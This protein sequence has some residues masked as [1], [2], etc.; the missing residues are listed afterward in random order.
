MG[1]MSR[2]RDKTTRDRALFKIQYLGSP[3]LSPMQLRENMFLHLLRFH[4]FVRQRPNLAN[5]VGL[6]KEE[7]FSLAG[8]EL[9]LLTGPD[10]PDLYKF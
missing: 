2:V 4:D 10:L 3:I 9:P 6:I 7:N 1:F 5:K 8:F